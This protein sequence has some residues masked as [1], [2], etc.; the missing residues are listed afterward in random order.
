M[1]DE[2]DSMVESNIHLL[3]K[4][5]EMPKRTRLQSRLCNK[6][7]SSKCNTCPYYFVSLYNITHTIVRAVGCFVSYHH[8]AILR[9]RFVIQ[10]GL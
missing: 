4:T 9:P 8:Y 7:L 6:F 2:R 3:K 10:G 1:S 5:Q